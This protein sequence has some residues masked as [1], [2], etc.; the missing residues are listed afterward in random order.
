[1][2]R[3][4]GRMAFVLAVTLTAVS[5][6]AQSLAVRDFSSRKLLHDFNEEVSLSG[7]VVNREQSEQNVVAEVLIKKG[8]DQVI[9]VDKQQLTIPAGSEKE[10]AFIWNPG[11]AEYGFAAYISLKTPGGKEI[12]VSAPAVFEV[13]HD[14][15]KVCR[16]GSF[17]VYHQYL[18]AD[19][20]TNQINEVLRHYRSFSLNMFEMFGEYGRFI[21]D[22]TP[23]GESWPYVLGDISPHPSVKKLIISKAKIKDWIRQSHAAGIKVIGYI[24]TPSYTVPDDSWIVYDPSTKKPMEMSYT[25]NPADTRWLNEHKV[26]FPNALKWK[27]VFAK[28]LAES[29]KEY[30]WDG[31]FLD[32]FNGL[33]E[34]TAK[35]V[36]KEGKRLTTMTADEV[37]AETLKTL[38]KATKAIKSNFVLV[39]NGLHHVLYGIELGPRRDMFGANLEKFKYPKGNQFADLWFYEG[40]DISRRANSPWQTGRA[41]RAVREATGR[42]VWGIFFIA[43][44]DNNQWCTVQA[45]N[46]FMALLFS[47]GISYWDHFPP[48]GK[49]ELAAAT[50]AYLKF[51]CRYGQYLYDLDIHWTPKGMV[52]V[53]APEHVY[54]KGN[55][56]QRQ[57]KDH[58]EVYVHLINFD[59]CYLQAKLQDPQRGVPAKVNNI[60]VT[61]NLPAGYAKAKAYEVTPDGDQEAQAVKAVVKDGK[62]RVTVPSLEYWDMLVLRL[63]K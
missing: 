58:L 43:G 61:V 1:M 53:N 33:C 39:P 48:H 34:N 49:D 4:T 21:G 57:F 11:T 37:Y 2:T 46:P 3:L 63:E 16:Q 54:W 38:A 9:Q 29:I 18:S 62:V 44:V 41:L 14:W 59:K 28:E 32:T 35:G 31:W 10:V 13:C 20:S 6:K 56:F 8:V 19:F 15:Q 23:E 25:D 12:A 60:R 50:A 36:D 17:C 51:A 24:H 45:V 7:I 52:E 55:T 5:V 27:D 42:P 26:Y 40:Q 22:L 47:N 30:D